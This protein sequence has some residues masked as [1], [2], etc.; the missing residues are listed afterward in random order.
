[1]FGL[2]LLFCSAVGGIAELHAEEPKSQPKALLDRIWPYE[3]R[4]QPCIRPLS[5]QDQDYAEAGLIQWLEAYLEPGHKVVDKRFYWAHR[6]YHAWVPVS[7]SHA[8]YPENENGRWR[9]LEEVRQP[10]HAPGIGLV[11]MWALRERQWVDPA[12]V[13]MKPY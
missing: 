7:K 3:L 8:L 1:M 2:I 6:K 9:I 4:F 13:C 5:K 12:F 10:R 11:R